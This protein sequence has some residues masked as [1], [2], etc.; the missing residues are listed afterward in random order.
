MLKI[1]IN[2]SGI[3]TEIH[4]QK[5]LFSNKLSIEMVN[6]KIS[7]KNASRFQLQNELIKQPTYT[8]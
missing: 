6:T 4:L 7:E 1:I 8:T 3:I 2:T 5:M